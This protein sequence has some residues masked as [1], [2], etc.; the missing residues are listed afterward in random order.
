MSPAAEAAL[1]GGADGISAIN[2][3]KSIMGVNPHSYVSS[4]DV[5]GISAVGG[6]SGNAVKPIALRFVAELGKNPALA[7]MHI[8]G[9]GGIE[10]WRDALEFLTMGASSIQV[11][12]A[13][14]QYGYRIID[15]LKS[16]LNYYLWEKGFASVKDLVGLALPSISDDIDVLERDT[17][18]FPKFDHSTCTGCGRC[19]LSCADG[20]HQAITMNDKRRPVL[21]G[22][23]CAGC[24]LCLL[25][26]PTHSIRSSWK[27]INK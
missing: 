7:N 1:R 17:V 4:P 18:V 2:T 3:I 26:C 10:T 6:Y 24:H 22:K 16:G 9:M 19:R 21:N 11:T 23:K 25:V 8:T 13:V 5:R 12:T 15:D 27:R 20:G 14:M